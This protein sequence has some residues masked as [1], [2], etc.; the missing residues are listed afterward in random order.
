MD[1]AQYTS[2][3]IIVDANL[4]SNNSMRPAWKANVEAK[5]MKIMTMLSTISAS[6]NLQFYIYLENGG[7]SVNEQLIVE[8]R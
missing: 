3:K 5:A 7:K 4:L 2:D 1:R 6:C 8:G